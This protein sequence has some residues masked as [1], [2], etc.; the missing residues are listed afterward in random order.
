[1]HY[2]IPAQPG[3]IY[4]V[5]LLAGGLDYAVISG[6]PAQGICGSGLVDLIAH[7]LNQ[8]KLTSRGKFTAQVPK[9]VFAFG[10]GDV[11]ATLSGADVDVFQRAKAAVGVGIRVLL[12][13]AGLSYADLQRVCVCGAFGYALNVTNAQAI[14]LLPAVRPER[15]ELCG[16]TALAGST[17]MLF[18]PEGVARLQQLRAKAQVVNLA[19]WPDF[20]E[21]F[22][23]HLYLHP[24]S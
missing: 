12:D 23:A 20:D 13:K 15:V 21:L 19:Q 11:N 8:G 22:L 24:A 3:A 6:G 18:S 1:M 4:R 10:L 17:E 7:L 2:G 14:G 9:A 5:T 16:N